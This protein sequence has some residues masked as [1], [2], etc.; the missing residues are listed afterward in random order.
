[1]KKVDKV[2]PVHWLQR[3]N[4]A[5]RRG[6]GGVCRARRDANALLALVIRFVGGTVGILD[7]ASR[8]GL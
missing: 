8:R 3:V 4:E 1:M 2:K 5:K 6:A 7:S